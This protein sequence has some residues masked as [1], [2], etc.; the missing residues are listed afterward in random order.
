MAAMKAKIRRNSMKHVL[1]GMVCAALVGATLTMAL[2]AQAEGAQSWMPV[3]TD[4]NELQQPKGYREWIYLGSL[5][6]PNGRNL[7]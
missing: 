2:L 6:T 7:L 4:K 1:E 3:W 5:V